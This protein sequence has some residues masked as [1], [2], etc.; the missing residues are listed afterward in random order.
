[1]SAPAP[2]SRDSSSARAYSRR[3]SR[4]IAC[5]LSVRVTTRRVKLLVGWRCA[6][7]GSNR[8]ADCGANLGLDLRGDVAV[9]SQPFAGVVLALADLVTVVCI[10]GSGL[11]DDVVH[12]AELDDF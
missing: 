2:I 10:P 6:A 8:H 12:H 5:A 9:L 7:T 11:L 3:A 4:R 1:M